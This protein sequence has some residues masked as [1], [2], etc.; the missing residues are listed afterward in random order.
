MGRSVHPAPGLTAPPTPQSPPMQTRTSLPSPSRPPS[1]FPLR[2]RASRLVGPWGCRC[3]FLMVSLS[4]CPQI[5]LLLLGLLP[6]TVAVSLA[7]SSLPCLVVSLCRGP[8][9]LSF[10]CFESCIYNPLHAARRAMAAAVP[11]PP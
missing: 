5:S 11:L 9:S 8:L 6:Q 4:V 7:S 3:R 10:F 2:G 1:F